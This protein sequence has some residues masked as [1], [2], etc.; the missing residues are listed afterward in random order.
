M[1]TKKSAAWGLVFFFILILVGEGQADT[2]TV[3]KVSFQGN[4]RIGGEA[5]R[6][7]IA[8]KPGDPLDTAP[9]REDLKAIYRMGYFTDIQVDVTEVEGGVEVTY[10]LTEK[11]TIRKIKISGNKEIDSEDIQEAFMVE[12]HSVLDREKILAGMERIKSLYAGKGYYT[13]EVDYELE[14]FEENTVVVELQ[15]N[16]EEKVKIKEIFILGNT[17]IS[18]DELLRIMETDTA[19]YFS[20]ITD[21]GTYT[22]EELRGDMDRVTSYYMDQGYINVHVSEPVVTLSRDKKWFSISFSIDEGKQFRVGKMEIRGELIAPREDLEENLQIKT[23]EIFSRIRLSRDIFLLSQMYGDRGYLYPEIVP[24]TNV[25]PKRNLVDVVYNIKKGRTVYLERID[26]EGNNRTRDKV[27]RR[28]LSIVEGELLNRKDLEESRR[29]VNRLGYFEELDLST[30]PGS[31][32]ELA[33]LGIMVKE[34]RTGM[35]S[36]GAG[37]SSVDKFM[38]NGQI[39][40]SNLFGRGQTLR[41][42]ADL[43]S[44]RQLFNL[45]FLEPYLFDSNWSLGTD[46]FNRRTEYTDFTRKSRGGNLRVGHSI[47]V[48]ARATIRYKYEDV[49]L[50]DVLFTASPLFQEGITSSLTG[51]AIWDTRDN[52][53]D[54]S[55]GF[56]YLGSIEYAGGPL[57]GD[58]QFTKYIFN[59]KRYLPFPW[60]TVFHMRLDLGYIQENYGEPIPIFERFFVGGINSVRGFESRSL[61]PTW[62]IPRSNFP[63][64]TLDRSFMVGG[65]KKLVFNMEYLFP[66]F[67]EMGLRGLV[68]FDAGNAFDNDETIEL[69]ELRTS[70]GFGIRWFSPVGPL[71][72]EWGFPLDLEEGEDKAVFQFSIGSPY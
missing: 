31:E 42:T 48:D 54:S 67:N 50:E 1:G 14:P 29:R 51:A 60:S 36:F 38:I 25:D 24:L 46:L 6:Q 68:F 15:I 30:S 66:I 62:E 72:F 41:L 57:G 53:L 64:S 9:F 44:R 47:A 35:L 17:I 71:R 12:S 2:V 33:R 70:V 55:E 19:G 39:S 49:E 4:R 28:E 65:N 18:D 13:T 27:V 8:V 58:S 21:S 37:F 59:G 23:G 3:V 34:K 26:V 52:R 40:E 20:W 5:I 16:E 10:I 63:T 56:F 61:G 22:E 45:G 11:P 32:E 7:V 69:S 43:G